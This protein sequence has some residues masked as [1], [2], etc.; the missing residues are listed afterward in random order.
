M[1]LMMFEY[2]FLRLTPFPLVC[3]VGD[4]ALDEVGTIP[5]VIQPLP[6]PGIIWLLRTHVF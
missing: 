4:K 1:L 3:N 2:I 5:V 6:L